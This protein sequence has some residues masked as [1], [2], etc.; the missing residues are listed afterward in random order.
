MKISKLTT[1]VIHAL[2]LFWPLTSSAANYTEI[3]DQPQLIVRDKTGV[4]SQERF[5]ALARAA[6]GTL[7]KILDSWSARPKIEK[8][9]K[10]RLEFYEPV[11]GARYSSRYTTFH[12][13]KESGQRV[14]IV[15]VFGVDV[16][17]Q[18]MAHKLTHAIFPNPDKLIRNMMG[19]YSETRFGNRNSFPMCGFSNDAWAQALLQLDSLIPLGSLGPEHGDWGMEFQHSR[20]VVHDRAKQHAAYAEAGSFGDYLIRTY[21][22]D[23]MKQFNRL[24]REN[25]RPWQDVYGASLRELENGWRRYLKSRYEADAGDVTL[26]KQLREENPDT[27][28]DRARDLASEKKL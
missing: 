16:Q 18:E 1:L 5:E 11:K 23:T 24:S 28:C 9:G 14:R 8:F 21:G 13:S 10:I 26:L 20:P 4:L 6:D 25:T 15:R 27:A 3:T 12:W 2:L 19:I 17:P 22:I 7:L